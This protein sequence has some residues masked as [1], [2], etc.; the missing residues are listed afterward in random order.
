MAKLLLHLQDYLSGDDYRTLAALACTEKAAATL[1]RPLLKPLKPRW[2]LT[3]C[4]R[5]NLQPEAEGG[6]GFYPEYL[7]ETPVQYPAQ[8]HDCGLH[9][10]VVLE[11]LPDGFAV[12]H[13]ASNS[14]LQRP[15]VKQGREQSRARTWSAQRTLRQL[16][17]FP[18]LRGAAL[19]LWRTQGL[20]RQHHVPWTPVGG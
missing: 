20:R 15:R 8:Q 3:F 9:D 16:H 19:R 10:F 1:A 7:A 17:A 4:G 11:L 14:Y 12:M 5:I 18:R 6:G 13:E 2:F